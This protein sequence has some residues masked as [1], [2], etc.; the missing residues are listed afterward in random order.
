VAQRL[1]VIRVGQR[2]AIV[3]GPEGQRGRDRNR[4]RAQ[5]VEID[6]EGGRAIV[7]Q[8]GVLQPAA[9]VAPTVAR[10]HIAHPAAVD[11]LGRRLRVA[12]VRLGGGQ[13]REALRPDLLDISARLSGTLQWR[14]SRNSC[15]VD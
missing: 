4:R 12:R 13:R 10:L 9:A 5:A 15:I 1:D 8:A 3:V 7:G 2:V 11:L 6:L 14:C